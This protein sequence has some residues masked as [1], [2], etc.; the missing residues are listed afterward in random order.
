MDGGGRR[1]T[2][3]AVPETHEVHATSVTFLG[4]GK[5]FLRLHVEEAQTHRAVTHDSCQVSPTAAAAIGLLG[6][7]G[8]HHVTT[9]PHAFGV[10]ISAESDTV[11]NGP[12]PDQAIGAALGNGQ[13]SRDGI[14]IIHR[15]Q[16][17]NNSL[18]LEDGS[19]RFGNVCA[20]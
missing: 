16:W 17:R 13:P 15:L 8:Y 11:T 3:T 2:Q 6:V 10:G 19:Q 9:F 20:L 18:R 7:E 12:N 1:S 14:G 4:S 5:N